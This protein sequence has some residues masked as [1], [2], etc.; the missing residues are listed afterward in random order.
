MTEVEFERALIRI[1]D[2]LHEAKQWREVERV[3]DFVDELLEQLD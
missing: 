2:E 3:E 1:K